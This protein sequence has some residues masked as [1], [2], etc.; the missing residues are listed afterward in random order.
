MLTNCSKATLVFT[1][2]RYEEYKNGGTLKYRNLVS[3]F[4]SQVIIQGEKYLEHKNVYNALYDF[5]KRS[6]TINTWSKER[7][8]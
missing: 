5:K 2:A 6:S 4:F 1:L 3:W 8:V 7:E